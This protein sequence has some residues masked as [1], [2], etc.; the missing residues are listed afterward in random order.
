V[1]VYLAYLIPTMYLFLQ[2]VAPR[3]EAPTVA[4]PPSVPTANSDTNATAP[5]GSTHT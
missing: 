3:Q 4:T 5:V 2:P 1:F